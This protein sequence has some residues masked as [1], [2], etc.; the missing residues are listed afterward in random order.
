MADAG[1]DAAAAVEPGESRAPGV[2]A[3][4]PIPQE[5]PTF[6]KWPPPRLATG[7][8]AVPTMIQEQSGEGSGTSASESKRRKVDD[9]GNTS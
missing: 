4:T 9:E 2:E 8:G 5:K 6:G 3:T 7:N 1:D